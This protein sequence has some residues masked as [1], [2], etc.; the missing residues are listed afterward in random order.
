MKP[1]HTPKSER[2]EK[3]GALAEAEQMSLFDATMI[4]EGQFDLA[5][6]EIPEDGIEEIYIEAAQVLIDTGAAWTLQGFFGR[7]CQTLIDE[8]HCHPGEPS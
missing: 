5:S 6:V 7:A 4:V 8:G 1:Y 3:V 2:D